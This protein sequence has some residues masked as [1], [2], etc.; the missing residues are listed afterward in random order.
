MAS[1]FAVNRGININNTIIPLRELCD[2]YCSAVGY[3]PIQRPQK[4]L[5]DDFS[6]NLTFRLVSCGILREQERTFNSVILTNFQQLLHAVTGLGRNR[7]DC[8][9]ISCLR[10]KRNDFQ[11][12]ILF[13][14]IDLI[15]RQHNRTTGCLQL[16]N[17]ALFLGADG[18]NGFHHH[19]RQIHICNRTLGYIHH[20]VAKLCSCLMKTGGIH[21]HE[22]RITLCHNTADSVT[23]SLGLIG[24]DGDF[25]ANQIICQGGLT[26][27]GSSG[28][29]NHSSLCCHVYSPLYINL[30]AYGEWKQQLPLLC[31]ASEPSGDLHPSDHSQAGAAW[32]GS[33]NNPLPFWYCGQIP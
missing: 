16:V 21:K 15:D 26:H 20:V 6:H 13:N 8:R 4:L 17:Q 10:I 29:G 9:K 5:A 12:D 31:F 25:L 1:L 28:N 33:L 22:L 24:N 27:I 11:Q 19:N 18:R 7:D 2:L 3:F 32:N 30:F 14:R 23:G